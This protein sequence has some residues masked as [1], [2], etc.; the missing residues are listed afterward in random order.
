MINATTNPNNPVASAR[1]KPKSKL[2][3]CFCAAEGFLISHDKQFPKIIPIPTPAPARA[4]AARPAPIIF[5]AS[6]SIISS[7]VY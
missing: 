4:I 7:Y 5:A 2:G 1:A 6:N 3:N